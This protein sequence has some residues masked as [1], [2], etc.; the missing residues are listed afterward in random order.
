MSKINA[1]CVYCGSS[2]GADPAFAE[3]AA[4]FGRILAQN[5]IRLV[6]GGG[7]VGLMGALATAVLENGGSVTGIIPDFLMRPERPRQIGVDQIVV[8]DIHARKRLM[9][10]QADAFVALPGGA[11][12]LEETIE[13]LAWA[14]L[15][16]HE[17]PILFANIKEFWAPLLKLL[18]HMHQLKFI[19][20]EHRFRYLVSDN[21][22]DILPKL[23]SSLQSG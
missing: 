6:Y 10:E 23:Y 15:G 14:Q 4:A 17:K 7:S 11:G 3:A 8:T 22:E 13:Q 19:H 21:I 5:R 1:V 9:F 2:P 12:T 16:R 18:Q 20:S